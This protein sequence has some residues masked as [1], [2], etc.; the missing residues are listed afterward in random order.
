[1]VAFI[2]LGNPGNAYAKTKHNIGF[3]VVNKFA[4]RHNLSFKSG[5]GEFVYTRFKSKKILIV[6]P[7]TYMNKSGLAVKNIVEFWNL[8][9]ED[10]YVIVDDVDLPL[11]TIRIRKKGGDGCHRGMKN[12]IYHLQTS[13]FPRIRLGIGTDE[14]MRPAEE[15]VL[16]PFSS[17][18]ETEVEI[19][20][21]K[22]TDAID[23]L[24]VRGINYTMNH[25]NS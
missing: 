24:L 10:T 16:K 1:M 18:Y 23:T 22:A 2:G 3:W 25:F 12:I 13:E 11:G 20:L 9:P 7:T 5:K 6:K 15:Y 4:D 14:V 17:K 21:K 19:M 8:L